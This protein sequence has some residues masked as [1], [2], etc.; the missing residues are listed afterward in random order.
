MHRVLVCF[1]TEEIGKEM[2]EEEDFNWGEMEVSQVS[3]IDS[4]KII[5]ET[6]IRGRMGLRIKVDLIK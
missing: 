4:V 6:K 5:L 3:R 1:S 2:E